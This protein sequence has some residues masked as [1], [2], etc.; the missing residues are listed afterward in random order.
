ML[1]PLAV[2]AGNAQAP[3]AQQ[4]EFDNGISSQ[5]K[6]LQNMQQNQ[7]I[8]QQSLNQDIKQRSREQQQQ[9]QLQLQQQRLQAQKP[10]SK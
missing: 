5:K 6:L 4:K 7:K 10:N 8:H 9:L 2:Q 3:S 1:L